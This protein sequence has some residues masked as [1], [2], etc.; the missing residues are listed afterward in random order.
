MPR[1]LELFAN[2]FIARELRTRWRHWLAFLI[3]FAASGLLGV[4]FVWSYGMSW[5]SYGFSGSG[6]DSARLALIGRELFGELGQSLLFTAVLVAPALTAGTLAYER[7]QGLLE[8]LQLAPLGAIRIAVGKYLGAALYGGLVFLCCA[9]F[10][11]F[12][13]LMGG[14][15]PLDVER[16]AALQL[17]TGAACAALGLAASAVSRKPSS[18]LGTAYVLLVIWLIGTYL[19]LPLS[20]AGMWAGP[21]WTTASTVLGWLARANPFFAAYG[22]TAPDLRLGLDESWRFC[23]KFELASTLVL[24]LFAAAYL[25]RPFENSW[26]KGPR[27]R[28]AKPGHSGRRG[29]YLEIPRVR[30]FRFRNPV[31]RRELSGMCRVRTPSRLVVL[32]GITLCPVGLVSYGYLAY[33]NWITRPVDEDIWP[34]VWCLLL[35]AAILGS[36]LKGAQTFSSEVERGTWEGLQLSLLPPKTLVWGKL[37]GPALVYLPFLVL[38]VPLLL[39]AFTVSGRHFVPPVEALASLYSVAGSGWFF[40]A[41]GMRI[42]LLHKRSAAATG[43]SIAAILA[44]FIIPL[45]FLDSGPDSDASILGLINP[46][47]VIGMSADDWTRQ[48]SPMISSG[49]PFLIM[50]GLAGWMLFRGAVDAVETKFLPSRNRLANLR[51]EP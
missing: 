35:L 1:L 40:A 44:I 24:I 38:S 29:H 14:V 47:A 27:S 11:A 32:L 28:E 9:P 15:A 30:W 50:S 51:K 19:A 18:A 10:M 34:L 49:I 33:K 8:Q 26:L 17:A 45:F 16:L 39:P 42:S 48:H 12:T 3:P 23:L 36:A 5:G 4:V 6:D 37:V 31:L 25:K 43:W 22:L 2:P 13:V 46:F 7:Q 41:L 20:M 21:S